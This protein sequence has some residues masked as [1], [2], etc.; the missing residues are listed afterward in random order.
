MH[1]RD[2]LRLDRMLDAC[3][4]SILNNTIFLHRVKMT[5]A[6]E[7]FF[8]N[9]ADHSGN[10]FQSFLSENIFHGTDFNIVSI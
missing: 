4:I 3:Q 8:R 6:H 9:I 7:V 2:P 5:V 10:L 1:S